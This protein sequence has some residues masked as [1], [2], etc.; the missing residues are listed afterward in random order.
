V[1]DEGADG[2][3]YRLL[4]SMRQYASERLRQAGEAATFEARH[5]D[6]YLAQAQAADP[7]CAT[8]GP[9]SPTGLLERDHDNLRAAIAWGLRH[10]AER[11]LRLAVHM[12]PMWMDGGHY[13]EGSRLLTAALASSP[14]P[15][16]LRAEALRAMCGLNV[17][18]GLSGELSRLGSE[19]LAI[20]QE[21]GDQHAVAHAL[22]EVG[23]YEYMVG[24][25]DQAAQ[26]Y[27]GSLALA[28]EL[29][30]TKAAAAA[31]HS[32]GVLE[33]CRA[34]FETGREA[35]LESLRLLR[36]LP[37]SERELFFRVHTVGLFVGP[38]GPGRVP[39]MYYEETL[40]F[41]RR[42]EAR[43]A[44]GYVLAGL[45][46]AAR[47]QGLTD[48]ARDRL[49]ES[50]AHFREAR[51]PM[52]TAFVLNRL[53]NLA[54][55]MGEY[56][57]GREWLDEGLELRRELGDRRAVGITMGNVG[58]LM[59]RA[60]DPEQA[61]AVISDALANFERR[62]DLPGQMGM[63]LALG[64]IAL[65]AGDSSRGRVLLESHREQADA[66]LLP[67]ASGW[68]AL[69]LAELDIAQGDLESA[70]TL[71]EEARERLQPL[72]DGWGLARALELGQTA[73]KRPLSPA[74]E[75]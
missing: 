4:E 31:L 68:A 70:A 46:D 32:I 56:E 2:Y 73:A 3:R 21:L 40:Q 49:N 53:G 69:R 57:L 61:Q 75:G 36:E 35:L 27:R 20:F 7:E 47:A 9:V 6:F 26:L 55:V 18:L 5:C 22:D 60:G 1:A 48:P 66:L 65:D 72:G 45:G 19:R 41:F 23:V 12:W 64:N 25:Y 67:R 13:R 38:E 42:V 54:G 33:Q 15:T 58:L 14:E 29:G 44:I 43:S 52:G 51:D 16:E 30:D 59:A 37:P 63:R 71:V 34:N 17:R 62:D 8:D 50:L 11:A 10:D 28:G 24:R 39:R 74:G